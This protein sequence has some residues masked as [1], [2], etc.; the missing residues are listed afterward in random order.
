MKTYEGYGGAVELHADHVV[1]RRDGVLAKASGKGATRE[2][3][4]SAITGVALKPATIAVNGY[5]QLQLD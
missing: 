2:I 5:I 1:I 4:L 3:P